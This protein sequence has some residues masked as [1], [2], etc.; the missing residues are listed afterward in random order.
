M[1]DSNRSSFLISKLTDIIIYGINI[2]GGRM[3]Q[4]TLSLQQIKDY[5]ESRISLPYPRCL[6]VNELGQI[7]KNTIGKESS[8]AQEVLV[9]LLQ[10]KMES[11][12]HIAIRYLKEL[13]AK[14]IATAKTVKAIA[15]FVANP[16]NAHLLPETVN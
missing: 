16:E 5:F 6:V 9:S 15:E 1:K 10:G 4:T 2:N 14:R 7:A 12:K 11:D 13:E 8:S 3:R